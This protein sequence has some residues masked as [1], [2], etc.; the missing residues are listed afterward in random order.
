MAMVKFWMPHRRARLVRTVPIDAL[1]EPRPAIENAL[2][3]VAIGSPRARRATREGP[4]P[5]VK[6]SWV[7]CVERIL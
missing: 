3:E 6:A 1:I 2:S 5:P 7:S 4:W